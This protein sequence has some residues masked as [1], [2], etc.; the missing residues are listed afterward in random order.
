MSVF[1]ES[2]LAFLRGARLLARIATLDDRGRLHVTPVGWSLATD[3][4]SIEVGG[5]D[6]AS[7]KKFRDVAS[8][9][10]A[11]IVIDE[12]LEPWRPRGVEVRGS[13]EAIHGDRPIIRIH[14]QRV[15]SWGLA[16][17]RSARNSTDA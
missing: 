13:A 14:P 3:E 11:A 1:T 16:Q 5:M 8:T 15:I 7:T 2:E 12:V 10:R 9:R 4:R 6:F 17:G